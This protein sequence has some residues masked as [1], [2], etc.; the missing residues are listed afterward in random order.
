M[1]VFQIQ[2]DDILIINGDKQYTDT[3]ENF[4]LDSELSLE[5]MNEVIYDELPRMQCDQQRI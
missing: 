5:D 2:K 3:I 1:R 4:G